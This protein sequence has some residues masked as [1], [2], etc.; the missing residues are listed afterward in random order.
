MGSKQHQF[1][2]NHVVNPR[3]Y[4]R[5][6]FGSAL[7]LGVG[8][9]LLALIVTGILGFAPTRLSDFFYHPYPST[10]QLVIVAID[11]ASIQEIGALPW[12]RATL[13]Q[14][15]DVIS[16]ATPRVIGLDLLLIEPSEEDGRLA[17]SLARAPHL[18]QPIVGMNITGLSA[19][20]DAVPRFGMTLAPAAA[21]QTPNSRLGHTLIE[22]DADGIVR[23]VPLVIASND[24]LF[25]AFGLAMVEAYTRQTAR[26]S[27]ETQSVWLGDQ[28][29][30]VDAHGQME[31][32]FF[33]HTPQHLLSAAAVLRGHVPP[34]TIRDKI[35]IVGITSARNPENFRT[36]LV[37]GKPVSSVH[38]QADLIET[39]LNRRTLAKQDRL[40]EIVMVFLI[41]L[42][43]G[44]TITHV[45][46]LSALALTIIY[47]LMYVGYAFAKF[48]EGVIVQP[49]Y[50]TL[51][52]ILML[53]GTTLYR[54]FS[55][56]RHHAFMTHL[57][58]RY[59]APDAANQ[60]A[61]GSNGQTFPLRSVRREATVL[62][63][64]LGELEPLANCLTAEALVQLLDEYAKIIVAAIFR[65]EGS[66]V[67][68]TG[69]AILAA[70]N[71]L[72]DQPAHAQHAVRA[73]IDL[74]REIVEFNRQ[75]PKELTIRIGMGIATGVVTAGRIGA[76]PRAE[77]TII[78][79]IVGLAERIAQ[80]PERGVFIDLTTRERLGDEF[81]MLEVKPV[82]LRRKT[83]PSQVWL[84]VEV[85]ETQEELT[86]I[87]V[88]S[89]PLTK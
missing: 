26:T 61:N 52:L 69:S 15:I 5:L 13:A 33:R 71:F 66:V 86:P 53:L 50:P 4:H 49:L 9:V 34:A 19:H 25:S 28:R 36:P 30:P 79:E 43:A 47:F 44:A 76:S 21:L 55:E 77:Y 42:T 62:A 78:G 59:L 83:D 18:V 89:S 60:M 41:A 14:L 87:P 23:R 8:F 82:R 32:N 65:Y 7:G 38:L 46:F 20:P 17:H 24:Q 67:K 27:I 68:Q 72:I 11:D 1:L 48:D 80:K 88:E 37:G 40:T 64:D 22:P 57:L 63:I 2:K 56:D 39:I 35:V 6:Q 74:R 51:A 10:E 31:L 54:Y 16:S 81:D 75:Q 70:W 58:K 85:S 12:S 73:A 84:L 29:L 3:V 45:R